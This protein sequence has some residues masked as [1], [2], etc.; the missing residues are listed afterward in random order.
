MN[1][2]SCSRKKIIDKSTGV[3][4]GIFIILLIFY[5]WEAQAQVDNCARTGDPFDEGADF[6][7]IDFIVGS[8]VLI[9]LVTIY[10]IVGN[11]W[12]EVRSNIDQRNNREK[13]QSYI[14][15]R[16]KL[17]GEADLLE[18]AGYVARTGD[19]MASLA[20]AEYYARKNQRWNVLKKK[21][22]S[23]SN[24]SGENRKHLKEHELREFE[25]LRRSNVQEL[26]GHWSALSEFLGEKANERDSGF[27]HYLYRVR[28]YSELQSWQ[29]YP[30][31]VHNFIA[32]QA[33]L[34]DPQHGCSEIDWSTSSQ[35]GI[36]AIPDV[37]Y[38]SFKEKLR[39]NLEE[40]MNGYIVAAIDF[41]VLNMRKKSA[42][43][44]LIFS[45]RKF[46]DGK[47]S[48]NPYRFPV[49][50]LARNCRE[51]DLRFDRT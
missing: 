6:N 18:Q 46:Q 15:S 22:V 41:S 29:S 39:Q 3:L 23:Y 48:S 24:P 17:L 40:E 26:C 32:L 50:D 12:S 34:K 7:L 1:N 9:F 33:M 38:L 44:S 13:V 5:G 37:V 36:P 8:S 25:D 2:S 35:F 31:T 47:M 21:Y 16:Y 14:V 19:P 28:K 51:E 11:L 49:G 20:L 10:F 27:F 42:C 45:Y 30:R 43:D 4:C